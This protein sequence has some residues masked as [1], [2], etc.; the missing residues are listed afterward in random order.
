[1]MPATMTEVWAS[2]GSS[3]ASFFFMW[4]IIS[5]YSPCEI[6][7][8]IEKFKKKLQDCF[9]PYNQISIHEFVGEYQSV[10]K[11]MMQ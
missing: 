5:Q 7:H 9:N 6:R 11:L 4:A 10:A 1:M 8:I 3:I 2:L